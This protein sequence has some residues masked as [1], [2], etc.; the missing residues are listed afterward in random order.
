MRTFLRLYLPASLLI[1]LYLFSLPVLFL[2]HEAAPTVISWRWLEVLVAALFAIPWGW[3]AVLGLIT[4]YV[5]WLRRAALDGWV[6]AARPIQWMLIIYTLAFAA[7]LLFLLSVDSTS[8]YAGVAYLYP[9]VQI[10]VSLLAALSITRL[11]L[12]AGACIVSLMLLLMF[13]ISP[14]NP[15]WLEMGAQAEAAAANNQ[16]EYPHEITDPATG[17]TLTVVAP[18][19]P[20]IVQIPHRLWFLLRP[21]FLLLAAMALF[22]LLYWR[23][24]RL[25]APMVAQET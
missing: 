17:E 24:K 14:N 9:V 3:L 2:L 25:P 6:A 5:V 18:P 11:P 4:L 15:A 8:P 1:V 16:V 10:L 12:F 20:T 22:C 23:A 21:P 13:P 19:E 7:T